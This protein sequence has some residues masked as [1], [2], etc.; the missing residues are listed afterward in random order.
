MAIKSNYLFVLKKPLFQI[1]VFK[2]LKVIA[3]Q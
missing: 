3:G 2:N 1:F